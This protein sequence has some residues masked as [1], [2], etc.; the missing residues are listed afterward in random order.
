MALDIFLTL[1]DLRH[2][3]ARHV[4][5]SAGRG[6]RPHTDRI[7]NSTM[8]SPKRS[9]EGETRGGRPARLWFGYA[10]SR[11]LHGRLGIQT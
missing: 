5:K 4:V 11:I 9:Q 7:G 1:P 6:G 10:A 8:H 3:W 2:R